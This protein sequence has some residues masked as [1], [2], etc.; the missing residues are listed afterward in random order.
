MI[1]AALQAVKNGKAYSIDFEATN[2][3]D[4]GWNV[5]AT[6]DSYKARMYKNTY[7]L[8]ENEFI[9]FNHSYEYKTHHETDGSE[10]YKYTVANTQE[11]KVY[12]VS[13]KGTNVID[14]VTGVTADTRFDYLLSYLMY[15][16]KDVDCVSKTTK[17][18]STFYNLA[19]NGEKVIEANEKI[20][21]LINSNDAEGVIK[22]N[23]YFNENRYMI[24]DAIVVVEMKNGEIAS[25]SLKT[26]VRYNPVGGDYTEENITLT[27]KISI[28]FNDNLESAKTYTAPKKEKTSLGSVGLNNAKYYIA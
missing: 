6:K 4:P 23:N 1:A 9:A 18:G 19:I 17:N 13:R 25:I 24:K 27:D 28:I 22:V 2:E 10:T 26:E 7:K 11:N 20:M 12:R 5:T 8:D 21:S 15:A 14:E 3:F 16:A